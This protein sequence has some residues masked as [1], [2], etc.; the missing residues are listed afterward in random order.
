MSDI[1]KG[2]TEIYIRERACY[3]IERLVNLGIEFVI[4]AYHNDGYSGYGT[5][6]AKKKNN[7][8]Y[9]DM[10]HCSCYGAWDEFTLDLKCNNMECLRKLWKKYNFYLE[11]EYRGELE[12][13]ITI[14]IEQFYL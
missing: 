11:E 10:G 5:A 3:G 8:F 14:I 4:Y 6:F 9:H 2:I 7:W 1:I 13:L 12:E